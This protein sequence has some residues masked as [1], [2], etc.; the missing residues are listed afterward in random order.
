MYLGQLKTSKTF[1]DAPEAIGFHINP[2][3]LALLTLDFVKISLAKCDAP[4]ESAHVE[5]DSV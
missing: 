5:L 4:R 1:I 2:S 3:I